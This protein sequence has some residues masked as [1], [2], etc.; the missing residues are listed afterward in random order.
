[1]LIRKLFAGYYVPFLQTILQ[2]YP[3]AIFCPL[4]YGILFER[5]FFMNERKFYGLLEITNYIELKVDDMLMFTNW[6]DEKV[7]IVVFD[8]NRV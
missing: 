3:L 8:K 7:D 4:Q 6:G 2:I 5:H 1:M